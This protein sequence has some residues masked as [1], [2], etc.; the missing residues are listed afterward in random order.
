MFHTN[1]N[2]CLAALRRQ[3]SSGRAL[4][5]QTLNAPLP[6]RYTEVIRSAYGNPINVFY[7]RPENAPE[8]MALSGKLLRTVDIAIVHKPVSGS[9]DTFPGLYVSYTQGM[10]TAR[11][12]DA[13]Y[14]WKE[15]ETPCS[16]TCGQG[17]EK[18]LNLRKQFSFPLEAHFS[19]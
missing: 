13:T 18:I 9:D 19:F 7:Y 2:L 11:F 1:F 12:C 4:L 14:F 6:R 3:D 5:R 10:D 16:V 15:R 17:V 8:V